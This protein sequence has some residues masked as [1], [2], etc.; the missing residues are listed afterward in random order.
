MKNREQN[1]VRL[2][3]EDAKRG[4][5]FEYAANVVS[6]DSSADK[7]LNHTNKT[8]HVF[9]MKTVHSLASPKIRFLTTCMK[10][11]L[12]Y[13]GQRRPTSSRLCSKTISALQGLLPFPA[14]IC[15]WTII[16]IIVIIIIIIIIIILIIIIIIIVI[17]IEF[18]GAIRDL[19]QSPH[20][21]ANCLQHVRSSGPGAI[22]CKSRATHRALITCKCHVTCHLVRRD[23]SAIKFDRVEIALI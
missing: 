14:T 12:L 1:Q 10:S 5:A 7:N 4:D 18:K 23:S 21:A 15:A 19:L 9:T 17:I 20:S 13:G 16:V 11:V 3:R 22:V 6:K 2:Q 8:T